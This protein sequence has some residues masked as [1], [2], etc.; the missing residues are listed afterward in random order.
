[1]V[2]GAEPLLAVRGLARRFASVDAVAG[3]DL[4][5]RRGE[6]VAL[7]G[8]NGAGKTT[9]LRCIAG[10]LAP[11]AGEVRVAGEAGRVARE[12]RVAYVPEL[13]VVYDDLTPGQHLAFVAA[14]RGVIDVDAAVD[15][16]LARTG[17]DAMRDRP[18]GVLSKGYRQRLCLAG[19]LVARVDVVLLDEPTTGLDPAAQAALITLVRE[20]AADGAAVVLSTHALAIAYEMAHRIVMMAAGR[21]A[22]VAPIDAF[23]DVNALRDAFLG[24]TA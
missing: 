2:E 23:A 11:S 4:D 6:I 1:M 19:A 18:A 20:I 24:A 22:L 13:P 12:R 5:V 16:A 3:V 8:P 10:V 7:L 21:I 17:L 9:T 15:R 14:A